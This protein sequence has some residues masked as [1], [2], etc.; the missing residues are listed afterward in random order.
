MEGFRAFRIDQDNDRIVAGFCELSL[1]DLTA[2]EVV[3]KV[4]HSTINY[5]DAL[6]ATGAGKIL[7]TYPLV[8]GIDLAG[9]VVS[10]E[11]ERLEPGTVVLVNGCGLSETVDGGYAEYA[12]VKSDSVV[13]VPAGMTA[14]QA[15]Q[16]GTAG[17]TAALA[18]QRMEQNNQLPEN[19]PIVVT[20]ATG[21]VGSIAVDM[22]DSRD[23]EVVALTGKAEQAEFLKSIGAH[24]VL[25]RGEV[26]LGKRPMEKARWGGA[27]D[28]LG[29]DVLTWLTRTVKYGGNIASIGLAA[30]PALNTTVLPFILRAV[31]LLGIN[32]VDTPRHL[33]LQVWERIGGDLHPRHLDEISGR[34]IEFD[35]LPDAF[36][37][38]IDGTVTGR[39]VVK[40]G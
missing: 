5:K 35:E 21:G 8:G 25:L 34:T 22:L 31:C 17:Y 24:E 6:A 1:D 14:A 38:Y 23:Y 37:A 30:S 27:I 4:S 16:I 13:P 20:G 32:S 9:T 29:G 3:I 10:S 33:R 2:G 28:N 12:R 7:R 18:I 15:M 39:T 11:D 26:D 36:Q 40:I 19:G